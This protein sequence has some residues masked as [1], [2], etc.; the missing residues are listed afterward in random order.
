MKLATIGRDSE[1][2]DFFPDVIKNVSH[3]SFQVRQLVVLYLGIYSANQPDLA[4]MSVNAFQ[5]QMTDSNA[6]VRLLALRS[7]TRLD[8][9]MVAPIGS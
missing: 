1:A 9:P 8:I 5:R 6:L 3:T 2:L 4:L 7:L